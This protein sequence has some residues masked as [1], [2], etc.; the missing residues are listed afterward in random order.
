[1]EPDATQS[2]RPQDMGLHHVI[3]SLFIT[4][5][6][7]K[8]RNAP[9]PGPADLALGWRIRNAGGVFREITPSS[10]TGNLFHNR[11]STNLAVTIP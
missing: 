11:A 10:K 1:M 5:F 7:E 4:N 2:H 8:S 9:S 6:P 3:L